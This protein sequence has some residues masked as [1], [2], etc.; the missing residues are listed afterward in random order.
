M[1][2][3]GDGRVEARVEIGNGVIGLRDEHHEDRLVGSGAADG[4][5]K[6]PGD[7]RDD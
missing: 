4:T 3:H 1:G 7:R 5:E 6:P 2:R